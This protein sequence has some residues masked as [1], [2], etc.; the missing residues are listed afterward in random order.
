MSTATE[1]L[2]RRPRPAARAPLR[3]PTARTP[4]SPGPTS[5]TPF[6]WAVDWFDAVARGND[7]PGA[8][9]RRG[10]RHAR[11]SARFD[12]MAR[13][14]RPGRGLARRARASRRGD[15]VIVMLGNQ[16]ELWE[17]M[18]AVM[19][20]GAV[21]M[22]TTTA[23][24]PADL[25]DRIARG[26]ARP[27]VVQRRPTPRKFDDGARRLHARQRGDQPSGWHDARTTPTTSTAAPAH[28]G[29]APGDRLLLY[30]T[31]GTTSQAQAGRA[32]PGVLPRRPPRRRCTGSACGPATCTSTSPRPAGPS[33]R[34]R[35]SSRRGS[36][37][38]RSSSTTTR[39][40][41]RPRC[42]AGCASSEVTVVLRAADG[43][44][45]ADQ[46]PTSPAARASLREVIGAGEPLNPEVI[47]Q[48]QGRVG[49]DDPRRLRPDRDQRR[50]SA[51]PRARR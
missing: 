8:G 17:S 45:D 42:S 32:H 21:I 38:R 5:A 40:S 47:E 2:P 24:G 12:E 29:T 22:P 7:T 30:F 46:R 10:G 31:S 48:V 3:T 50:R 36:R 18:L 33:T 28:P 13:A 6:N 39:A 9:D 51:T 49:A 25:A 14:L 4:S 35:A 34:G 41:T 1:P 44:A 19:K 11:P 26:G 20:L 23:V 16:V 27:C 43:V 15:A 37:R